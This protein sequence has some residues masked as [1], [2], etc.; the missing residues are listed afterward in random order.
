M[1]Q[2]IHSQPLEQRNQQ[3]F[4]YSKLRPKQ[5][6]KTFEKQTELFEEFSAS[7]PVRTSRGQSNSTAV[8][9]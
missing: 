4:E 5:P 6:T 3:S 7:P 9:V 1:K 2:I 8:L